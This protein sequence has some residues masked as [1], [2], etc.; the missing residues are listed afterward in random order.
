MKSRVYLKDGAPDF[1][2]LFSEFVASLPKGKGGAIVSFTGIVREDTKPAT[3]DVATGSIEIEC[4]E[5]LANEAL[6]AISSKIEA[7]DGI[8][9]VSIIHL[10]GE[11]LVGEPMVHVLV[12]GAHRQEAFS[13]LEDAVNM[14][15]ADAPLWKK[16]RYK[17]GSAR[18]VR[19]G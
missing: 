2:S 13:A 14:Y 15:K 5:G 18:W 7:R 17:D 6:Q 16:E 9:K 1:H 12:C 11:F 19:H 3:R 4:V 8:I 10:A